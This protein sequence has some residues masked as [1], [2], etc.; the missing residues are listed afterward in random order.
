MIFCLLSSPHKVSSYDKYSAFIW[1]FRLIENSSK[2]QQK[3]HCFWPYVCYDK[4]CCIVKAHCIP[5]MHPKRFFLI[6]CPLKHQYMHQDSAASLEYSVWQCLLIHIWRGWR[7]TEW[8]PGQILH[9]MRPYCMTMPPYWMI[10]HLKKMIINKEDDFEPDLWFVQRNQSPSKIHFF[11]PKFTMPDV[12]VSNQY[13]VVLGRGWQSR[14][15]WCCWW[16]WLVVMNLVMA[17]T[18]NFVDGGRV[19][20]ESE[21]IGW[22]YEIG[23]WN[24]NVWVRGKK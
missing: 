9:P 6:K 3:G 24:L 4:Q 20:W 14:R 17:R 11:Y 13:G 18:M 16:P 1:L 2:H 8:R 23:F 15:R 5:T 10:V 22:I 12:R 21:A 7:C 19:L